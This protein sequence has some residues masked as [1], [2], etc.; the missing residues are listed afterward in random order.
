MDKENLKHTK[1]KVFFKTFGC[2][3]NLFDT[4][5]MMANLKDFILTENEMEADV[6]VVNSCTVTNGADAGVRSYV[7]KINKIGKKV[8]F[9]GCGV[10]TQGKNLFEKSLVFGTFAHSYKE[11][12]ND[13]LLSDSRFFYED[14]PKETHIDNT[15]VKDFSSKVRAFIKIQEGCD[16]T[17]SYCIIPQVR[18]VARSYEERHILEQIRILASSGV[19]E[20]VLTGTNVGSYGRDKDS[21]I[22]Q[23]ILKISKIDGI[24]RIRVGSMEPSQVDDQFLDL[25]DSGILERHLHIALQHSHDRML[26]IMN[27]RNRT[28]S[29]RE[30]LERVADKG[31]AIGTDYIV[32]HPG[33]SEKIWHEALE[34]LQALPLTHIHPFIYSKR[35]G[36]PSSRLKLD[37]KGD[38]AKERLHQINTIIKQKNY[39]FRLAHQN[40]ALEVLLDSHKG[41]EMSGLDQFFN[42]VVIGNSS[43]LEKN[44]W[45]K[46]GE[47]EIK[48]EG[49]Y[50]RI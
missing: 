26:E 3:T 43:Q 35:D 28:K 36:T 15:I 39:D 10:K 30:L 27:R 22:A 32:G 25:L 1:P 37:V 46:I 18:G 38:V 7:N 40:D 50:A 49:N 11:K 6:I 42:K 13:F 14:S 41:D 20:V 48:K 12:I 9:T 34:N 2:R 31:C 16:F 19:C 17:C 29:D 33:E 24:K 44:Q 8:L 5:V 45:L 47:Y 4:Q 21:S 23:L